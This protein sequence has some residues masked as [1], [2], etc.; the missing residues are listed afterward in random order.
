[1]VAEYA[2]NKMAAAERFLRDTL[3]EGDRPVDWLAEEVVRKGIC[4]VRTLYRA[5]AR[6][7][8]IVTLIP[9]VMAGNASSSGH[10]SAPCTAS[11]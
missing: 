9:T 3:G 5:A 8:A 7:V 10:S 4:G 6:V 11:A 1:M 2:G